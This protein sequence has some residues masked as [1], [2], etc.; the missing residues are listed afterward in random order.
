MHHGVL[1]ASQEKSFV[2][3]DS[4]C[5]GTL[6]RKEILAALQSSSRRCVCVCVVEQRDE[7]IC[8]NLYDGVDV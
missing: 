5:D 1:S 4:S 3:F 8:M 7:V 6:E 2:Y